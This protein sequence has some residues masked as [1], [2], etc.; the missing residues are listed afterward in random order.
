[1]QNQIFQNLRRYLRLACI[2]FVY[3]VTKLEKSFFSSPFIAGNEK[4]EYEDYIFMGVSRPCVCISL[5][6]V[7]VNNRR[8]RG[9]ISLE[10][11]P[12]NHKRFINV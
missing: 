12:N 6:K 8:N 3:D 4:Q 10:L 5:I 1:M 11:I 7:A 2:V 9:I